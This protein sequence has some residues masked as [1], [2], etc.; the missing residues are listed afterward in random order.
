MAASSKKADRQ[1]QILEAAGDVFARYGYDK[2]TLEDIGKGAGLN[3]ASLYY[4]FKNKEEIFAR[5]ILKE[6]QAFIEQLQEHTQQQQGTQAKITYYLKERIRRYE[7]VINLAQLSIDSL[8]KVEPMFDNLYRKV[9]AREITFLTGLLQEGWERG[10]IAKHDAAVLAE[11]LFIL[12]DALKHGYIAQQG[13]YFDPGTKDFYQA[14]AN[15]LDYMLEL[16]FKGLMD[17]ALN[18]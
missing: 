1:I 7:E 17:G 9:K 3:K 5:V 15:K 11:S 6:T 12:S 4:Y 13:V 8:K 2:T 18:T 14:A 10:E 16:L